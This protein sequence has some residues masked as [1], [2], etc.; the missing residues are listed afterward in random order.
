MV[1]QKILQKR[2]LLTEYS[3]G[4]FVKD[5]SLPGGPVAHLP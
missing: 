2:R 3:A 1:K 5:E 4:E